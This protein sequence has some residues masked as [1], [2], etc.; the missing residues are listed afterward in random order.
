MSASAEAT[1][2]RFVRSWVERVADV[3]FVAVTVAA[4]AVAALA[5]VL[6]PGL[7]LGGS[8]CGGGGN[9][10]RC[11]GIA[12]QLSLVDVSPRAWVYVV[13]GALCA[14]LGA[15]ALLLA[16]HRAARIVLSASVLCVALFGLVQI[17]QI[18]AKLGPSG[19]GTY[20]RAVED[21][22]PFLS[23]ALLDL[24][25][26]TLRRYAGTR[27]EPGGPRYD[28]EQILD[29]FSVRE[30]DGWRFLHAAV[31]VLFFAAGL[32]TV[33][34]VIPSLS[35]AIVTTATAGLVVWAMVVDRASPC[36]PG[37]SDC[38][39]GLPTMFALLA[40]GLAWAAY[41]AGFFVRRI[42]ERDRRREGR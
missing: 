14:V 25:Q 38:Y 5:A 3:A 22:G 6:L 37:A 8:A 29:T 19:C 24:R 2:I 39:R 34:R 33:R 36:D 4:G 21:W 1:Y 18:D 27:T 41:L 7:V 26:D 13:G 28:R 9:A 17:T 15:A 42:V 35:L 11:T 32:E 23:P 40:A 31:L 12:R 30:Q 20:G 16:R 10:Q